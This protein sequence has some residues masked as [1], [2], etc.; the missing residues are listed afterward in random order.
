M[1]HRKTILVVDDIPLM[2]TILAKY[3]K[4]LGLK[5]LSEDLGVGGIEII[6]ASNG[7]VALERLKEKDVDL[8]FLDLMMP[9]MDGLTFLGLKRDDTRIS[10]IPVIVCSALGE[11]ETVDRAREL[12]AMSYIVKPFTLK[13]VEEKFREA[14]TVLQ[15]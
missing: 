6:E 13:S 11:K 15:G 9:E 10:S 5:I 14:M 4:S 1:T 7:K 12:G 3:V 8:I 2:R